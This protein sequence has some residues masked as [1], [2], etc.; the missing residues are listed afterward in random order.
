LDESALEQR[1]SG[2]L[3]RMYASSAKRAG[4]INAGTS[5]LSGGG[6]AAQIQMNA[7]SG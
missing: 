7:G 4:I 3:Q 5:L 1:M 2:N 6:N